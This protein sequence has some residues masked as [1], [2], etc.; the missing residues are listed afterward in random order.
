MYRHLALQVLE[1]MSYLHPKT[2]M[3]KWYL[4]RNKRTVCTACVSWS[5]NKRLSCCSI[6]AS[7]SESAWRS[8]SNSIFCCSFSDFCLSS[9]RWRSS[10]DLTSVDLISK[11]SRS[12][13]WFELKTNIQTIF[14]PVSTSI[15]CVRKDLIFDFRFSFSDRSVS[16]CFC[17]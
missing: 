13:K 5:I 4:S 11:S 6:I 8:F 12:T 10:G 3:I 7:R 15:N 17:K 14:E 1:Q 16:I 9:C 2:T